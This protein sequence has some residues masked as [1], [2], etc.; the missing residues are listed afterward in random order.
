MYLRF[1]G[2]IILS[3]SI[4]LS[5]C[6]DDVCEPA[7][8]AYDQTY[9]Y[10]FTAVLNEPKSRIS[11]HEIDKN[12][13]ML[14]DDGDIIRLYR[15]AKDAEIDENTPCYDFIA[16]TG[17]GTQRTVFVHQ[18]YIP[19]W[20]HFS[21]R[22]IY[23]FDNGDNLN[24]E[25][26]SEYFKKKSL[27]QSKNN[28]T[29]HIKYAEH[30]LDEDN[31]KDYL[32]YWSDYLDDYNL[33]H[34]HEMYFRHTT[35]VV[36]KVMLRGFIDDIPNGSVLEMS[37][38]AWPDGEVTRL[39]LGDKD[40]VD[41]PF[42]KVGQYLEPGYK[43]NVLIAYIPRQVAGEVDGTIKK[44]GKLK[45]EVLCYDKEDGKIKQLDAKDKA[46]HRKTAEFI[47][48]DGNNIY[49]TNV[50]WG[51]EYTWRVKASKDIE[52]KVGDYV[53]ADL[54]DTSKD[55]SYPLIAVEMGLPF[56]PSAYNLGAK[57]VDEKGDLY[58]WGA[59]EAH[60]TPANVT[61]WE[62]RSL[63]AD[64]DVHHLGSWLDAATHQWGEEWYM[65]SAEELQDMYDYCLWLDSKDTQPTGK[66]WLSKPNTIDARE[67]Y[68]KL[69]N[70]FERKIAD[71]LYAVKIKSTLT[72][73]ERILY[74]P[75]AGHGNK[76][77]ETIEIN[78]DVS[79][80]MTR[81]W[82][83]NTDGDSKTAPW[84]FTM[85]FHSNTTGWDAYKWEVKDGHTLLN[86]RSLRPLKRA[87]TA[88]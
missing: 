68:F 35:T 49:L 24:V 21:G 75:F 58:F 26:N 80:Y 23:V 56:K 81:C 50:P 44:D 88:K 85:Q 16:N 65:M 52:Y 15:V 79:I 55:Y 8:D 67:K 72:E 22:A 47:D 1:Y 63:W 10:S 36:Y 43:D 31:N 5:A 3:L 11:Y 25:K 78:T 32:E 40:K 29:D 9:T 87:K 74:F 70:T 33:K 37:G 77:G 64:S 42:L 86:S 73:K 39:T 54:T 12:L 7:T 71:N 20:E 84:T 38:D 28:N 76:A 69:V 59:L 82:E 2:I 61:N 4:L 41:E 19:N 6:N 14:W 46:F 48:K 83:T 62:D 45:F 17:K 53:V 66:K 51:D 13:K 18:G 34:D 57:K 60:N 30:I 27:F